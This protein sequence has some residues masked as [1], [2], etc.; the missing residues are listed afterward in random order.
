[1][2]VINMKKAA[3]PGSFDPFT[4]GH[5]D[6][7]KRISKMFDEVHIVVSNNIM[8]KY[9]FTTDERVQMIKDSIVGLNNIIVEPYDGLVVQYCKENDIDIIVRGMRNYSDYETEF[10]LFQYNR[11]I[12][13]K[14]ETIL[15]MPTTKNLMVSSSSIKELV[16]FGVDISNY[17]P[18]QIVERVI[19]KYNIKK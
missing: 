16:A 15:L 11:A 12:Y 6:V 17:V 10:S 14:I 2:L 8:K 18:K 7:I 9:S 4:N 1:M 13:P 19:E 3:Y 5:L